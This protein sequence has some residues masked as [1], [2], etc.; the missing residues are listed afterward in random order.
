MNKF[1]EGT[2]VITMDTGQAGTVC[3]KAA[4]TMVLLRNGDIWY[5]SENKLR[6]PQDQADL[7][8]AILDFDRFANRPKSI[9]T[10]SS[11]SSAG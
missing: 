1:K 11:N 8:A 7:D 5:G 2:V 3:G 9:R 4:E 6:L 10:S